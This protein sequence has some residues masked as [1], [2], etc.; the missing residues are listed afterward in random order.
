MSGIGGLI[1]QNVL[2]FFFFGY[3]YFENDL[4]IDISVFD[5]NVGAAIHSLHGHISLNIYF[6]K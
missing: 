5:K 2:L 6:L 1:W 4:D 3:F